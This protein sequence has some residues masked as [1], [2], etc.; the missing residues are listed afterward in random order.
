MQCKTPIINQIRFVRLA[1]EDGNVFT[2]QT[3]QAIS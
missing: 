3:L 2:V 1:A